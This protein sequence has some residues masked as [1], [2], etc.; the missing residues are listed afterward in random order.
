MRVLLPAGCATGDGFAAYQRGGTTIATAGFALA[1]AIFGLVF[2][3]LWRWE[4]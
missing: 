2:P 3:K 1:G 4:N